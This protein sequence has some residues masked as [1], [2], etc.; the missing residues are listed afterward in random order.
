MKNYFYKLADHATS[1]IAKEEVCLLGFGGETSDFC[2]FN[3]GLVRQG[4]TVNECG[5]SLTLIKNNRQASCTLNLVSGE[6]DRKAISDSF[7]VLRKR[8]QHLPEDPHLLYST[9]VHSS[10]EIHQAKLI[11]AA[12]A[13]DQILSSGKGLQ[14]VGIYASG[15]VARGF[16]NS[17]GQRNWFDRPSFNLDW[18]IYHSSDKA[19]KLSY[20][21]YDWDNEALKAKMDEAKNG[22][23]V[24]AHPAKTVPPGKY[25]AYLTPTALSDVLNWVCCGS[26]LKSWKT[27]TTPLMRMLDGQEKMHE[28]VSLSEDV[29]NGAGPRFQEQGFIKPLKVTFVENG[30]LKD[31]LV[32]PRSA[33]EFSAPHNGAS[34]NEMPESL[35]MAAGTLEKKEVL[36]K[37]GTGV[38]ISNTWYLNF[39]DS[40][41]CKLT[42]MTRYASWWVEN[43]EIV[44]PL[45]VM[46]FDESIYRMLGSNLLGL[47]KERDFILD[48]S[49]YMGRSTSSAR[50]PGVL[51]EDFTFTL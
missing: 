37:L 21:G 20:A 49:T 5:I 4:G 24:L 15:T 39:S 19:I 22:L 18:S 48:S 27:K 10:E 1:V 13:M 3:N 50:L 32:S 9:E 7:D 33:R 36:S 40:A 35:D 6:A 8:L 25:R 11:E 28:S 44:A 51:V 46:R 38:Y 23:A 41:A 16:A 14:M 30:K 43:G 29:G 42:G 12:P 31:A 45:N 2:R 26:G 17:L 34:S 47:T